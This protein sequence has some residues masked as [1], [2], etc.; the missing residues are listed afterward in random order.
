MAHSGG[1]SP[2]I[3][4][5]LAAHDVQPGTSR[6]EQGRHDD[7]MAMSH[8]DAAL[9]SSAARGIDTDPQALAQETSGT[10]P[11]HRGDCPDR[12]APRACVTMT[13]CATA[14]AVPSFTIVAMSPQ[15]HED[16]AAPPRAWPPL[17]TRA[18]E[19]P[20]PRA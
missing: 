10:M 2:L 17:V 15:L 19:L 14:A 16:V 18:P 3:G 11:S 9:T 20:P 13:A 1:R 7:G 4:V 5:S 6:M 8:G 12:E